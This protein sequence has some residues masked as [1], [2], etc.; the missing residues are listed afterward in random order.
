MQNL[1]VFCRIS[2][3]EKKGFPYLYSIKS[4]QKL[5]FIYFTNSYTYRPQASILLNV[6]TH[7]QVDMSFPNMVCLH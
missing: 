3:Y 5:Y 7:E 1:K 6:V 2:S 4:L